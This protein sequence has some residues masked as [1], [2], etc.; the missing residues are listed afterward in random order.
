GETP[1]PRHRNRFNALFLD[2]HVE[3][4]TLDSLYKRQY[5]IRH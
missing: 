4:G 3:S 2:G 1:E 5:F